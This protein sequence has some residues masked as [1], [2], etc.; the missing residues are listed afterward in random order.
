MI[1]NVE[2]FDEEPIE[3]V[4]TGMKFQIDKT[5]FFGYQNIMEKREKATEAFLI[6]DIFE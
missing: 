6:I 2:F 1:V 5:I 4:M 3:N